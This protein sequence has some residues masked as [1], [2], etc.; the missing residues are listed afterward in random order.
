MGLKSDKA[1][2]SPVDGH[3]KSLITAQKML[4][5][6]PMIDEQQQTSPS[7]LR[8]LAVMLYDSFLVIALIFVVNAIALGV[9]VKLSDG[10]QDVV[11]PLVGQILT[12]LCILI[13]FSAFWLKSGQTLGMQ[14][15]RIKLVRIGGGQ[16]SLAQAVIRC[17]A[18][19]PSA[20][21]LGLGYLWRLFDRNNRYW[22]DYLSGTELV[23]LPKPGKK[24][25]ESEG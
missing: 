17:F 6:P 2:R 11:D 3:Y 9:T 4:D 16:P 1:R 23:L 19:A 5:S 18:A 24:M 7:L 25:A 21:C 8:H 12:V 14:A 22:H 13:F 20:A 10:Q 15:W